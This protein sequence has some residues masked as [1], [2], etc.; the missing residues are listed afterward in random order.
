M[1]SCPI[2]SINTIL[3]FA[4][5][6]HQY[7][8]EAPSYFLQM[9]SH[10]CCENYVQSVSKTKTT[11]KTLSSLLVKTCVICCGNPVLFSNINLF[12]LRWKP[13][14]ISNECLSN[15]LRK[16]CSISS[17]CLSNQLRKPCS[18]PSE[19][20]SN[21]LWKPCPISSECLSNQLWKPCSFSSECLVKSA[22][23]TLFY[24]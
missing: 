23:E 16:P 13:C 4:L 2:Y 5:C 1:K 17:E 10:Y 9:L 12:H 24:F 20:P 7:S 15:Q 8:A 6:V 18:V 19:C 22:A 14:P 21:L 11:L 3:A